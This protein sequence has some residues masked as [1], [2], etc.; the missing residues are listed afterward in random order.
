MQIAFEK[1]RTMDS[2]SR[3]AYKALRTNI[4]FCG[5]DI[6]A[7][8]ITSS[9]PNEGKSTV[10]FSLAQAFAEDNKQVLLIDADNRKSTLEY[11]YGVDRTVKGL[12][13]F[14]AGTAELRDVLCQTNIPY[15]HIILSGAAAPNPSELLGN[16]KFSALLDGAREVYDYIFVDSPPIGS[17]IDAAVV[18]KQCDGVVYVV[19][20]GVTSYHLAKRGKEQIEK[21]GCRILGAVLNKVERKSKGYG[22]GRYY[23]DYYKK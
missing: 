6:K 8:A 2:V 14:L 11:R 22:Y 1:L 17:V 7:I 4:T 9:M 23:G 15:F 21:S 16:G 18:A 12:S 3:E 13:H 19:E 20:S 5:E 10:A